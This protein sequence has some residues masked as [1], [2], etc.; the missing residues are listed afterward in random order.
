M[1]EQTPNYDVLRDQ[2]PFTWYVGAGTNALLDLVPE[3][4]LHDI[5]LHPEAMI[6]LYRKGMPLFEEMFDER[7][8]RPGFTTPAI[9]YAHING[10]GIDLVFPEHGEVNY[11]HTGWSLDKLISILEKPIDWKNQRMI[12]FYIEYREKMKSAFPDRKIA[13][14]L[15]FEGPMTTAY[16]LRDIAA[17]TD[18][19]D[20][21][22][23]F[24]RFM[25]IVTES[26]ID[27][28]QFRRDLEELPQVDPSGT[29]MCDDIA[30]MFSPEVW[31]EFVLPFQ[32]Q[33]F[34]GLT[35][36]NRSA[37]IEDLRPDHLHFLEDL[38]LVKFDPSISP[39]ICPID[40]RDRCRV[41]FGWRLG[42]FHYATMDEQ[43]VH[44]WVFK[45]VAEGASYVFTHV[46]THMT[47]KETVG[48][49]EAFMKAAET[50]DTMLESGAKKSDLLAEISENGKKR[51][52]D[53]WP[54]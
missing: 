33:Y 48:K 39:K 6:E 5:N 12:P 1:N 2:F 32:H 24:K 13:I 35:E 36:G 54:D 27:F 37:H 20:Q 4:S 11:E 41:P 10:L 34:D 23:K 19:Y 42:N 21:P 22:E 43:D 8:R 26:I 31:E 51:F 15:G 16:E 40:I 25:S 45:A 50:V 28:A 52:W 44:D 18:I 47:N 30:S 7:V 38:R 9:S 17:F 49:V 3:I 29:G 53:T 46:A 14:G